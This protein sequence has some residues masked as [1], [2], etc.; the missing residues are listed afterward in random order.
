M[1]AESP[2][3]AVDLYG[4]ITNV[5]NNSTDMAVENSNIILS[6]I[7]NFVKGSNW[8]KEGFPMQTS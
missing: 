8:Y 2:I 4:L 3:N 6:V 7:G 5:N 1:D